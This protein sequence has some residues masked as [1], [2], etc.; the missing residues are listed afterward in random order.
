M[1]KRKKQIRILIISVLVVFSLLE[2]LVI[3]HKDRYI[4][5]K[6]DAA[7]VLGY[8][9]KD[10]NY[11]S[12][13]LEKRL[14]AS[15]SLY[16]KGYFDYFIV[17]GGQGPKDNLAVAQAMKQ[18]LIEHQVPQQIIFTESQSK[19]TYENMKYT[20]SIANTHNIKSVIIITSDF[21]IFRS[22]L[23][24]KNFFET[25]SGYSSVSPFNMETFFL[26]IKEPFS[27]L[28]YYIFLK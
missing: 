8:S 24:G 26:Y 10:G 16:Q 1:E 22:M 12:T 21:H 7:L 6:S 17:S 20:Q 27:L 18:W 25:I 28:K 11:P 3:F 9:L 14:Q 4:P 15:L 5:Q 23:I 13:I 19:N 2:A